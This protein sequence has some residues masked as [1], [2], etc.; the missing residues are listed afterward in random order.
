M[1]NMATTYS[2]AEVEAAVRYMLSDRLYSRMICGDWKDLPA[3]LWRDTFRISDYKKIGYVRNAVALDDLVERDVAQGDGAHFTQ[4]HIFPLRMSDGCREKTNLLISSSRLQ[5]HDNWVMLYPRVNRLTP[6][7]YRNCIRDD[8]PFHTKKSGIYWR[9][10]DSGNIIRE[11]LPGR[12]NRLK[13][14]QA[15]DGYKVDGP[16]EDSWDLGIT[17]FLQTRKNYPVDKLDPLAKGKTSV[18]HLIKYKYTL[19]LPGND[20][21]SQFLW[22]LAGNTVPFHPYPFFYETYWYDGGEGRSALEP[23]VHFIPIKHDASDLAEKYEWCLSHQEEC[24]AVIKAGK[25]HSKRHLSDEFSLAVRDRFVQI[26]S[27]TSPITSGVALHK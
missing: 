15:W 19:C 1:L 25:E 12:C 17:Q 26:Y 5:S 2:R 8:V 7:Y 3:P 14:C 24:E 18:H 27:L 23:W 20:V 10:V 4:D 11:S 13:V 9:G 21:S 6:K 16:G 22:A